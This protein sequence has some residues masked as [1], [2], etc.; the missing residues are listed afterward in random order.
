MPKPSQIL[1]NKF[2]HQPTEG[3]D[4]IFD[5]LDDFLESKNN[6]ERQAFLIKGY[7]GTGKTSVIS[8]LVKVLPL[9]NYKYVLLA[10]TGRAAKVISSYAKRVA[11]TI[12]KRIYKTTADKDSGLLK[13]KKQKNYSKDTIFIVDEASMLSESQDFGGKGLLND[14]MNYVFQEKSNKLILIGDSAQLPPVGQIISAGLSKSHLEQNY[15]VELNEIEL[16]EVMRQGEGSG[17]LDN[18]TNLRNELGK[19]EFNIK[20]STKNYKDLFRMNG[21]KMEDGI[22]YAFDKYGMENTTIICR[23]NQA[24]IQYNQFVRRYIHFYEDQLEAGDMLMIVR[25]NYFYTP[26]DTPGGFLANGDFVILEKVLSYEERHGF[27]FAKMQLRMV[28]YPNQPSFEAIAL[29]DTLHMNTTALPQDLSKQLY[30]YVAVDYADLSNAKA[31]NEAIRNDPYLNALQIKYAYALTC[32]KS[33]GGQWSSVFVDQGYL[34]DGKIDEEYIRWL[35]TAM[36]R[37][38]DELFLVNFNPQFFC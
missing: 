11:F 17:I 14:L 13:F 1:R 34:P 27:N 37:A 9:F 19:K 4:R 30:D 5:L 7:A 15:G 33:Q 18:A 22:R 36:T 23:S 29:L 31:R 10:P 21:D 8:V 24:A 20:I 32:H 3:Q 25:N 28:D 26:D 38:T 12:H 35:Y 6:T 2:P 16:T